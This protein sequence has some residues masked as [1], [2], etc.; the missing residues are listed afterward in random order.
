MVES[1]FR[2]FPQVPGCHLLPVAKVL[3]VFSET[4]VPESLAPR[5]GL[6]TG[7]SSLPEDVSNAE[8]QARP[9]P[10]SLHV[11]TA[12]ARAAGRAGLSSPGLEQARASPGSSGQTRPLPGL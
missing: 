3:G 10:R 9:H 11:L 12:P 8:A 6:G 4:R 7:R 2:F 1:G 5:C